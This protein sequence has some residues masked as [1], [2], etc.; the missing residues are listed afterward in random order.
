MNKFCSNCGAEVGVEVKICPKCNTALLPE[1][2]IGVRKEIKYLSAGCGGCLTVILFIIFAFSMYA[3]VPSIFAFIISSIIT[4]FPVILYILAILWLDRHEKEP[5]YLIA[6][7]FLW[8]ALV[9]FLFSIAI[10]SIYGDFA[11]RLISSEYYSSMFQSCIIAPIVEES[12]KGAALLLLFIFMRHEFDNVTDG[13]IY[14][15]LIGLGF[16][17]TEDILYYARHYF[18]S[19][20]LPALGKIFLIRSVFSGLGHSLYTGTTGAGLGF[21]R[22]TNKGLAV[23]IIVP[24]AAFCLAMAEHSLWNL[25][26]FLPLPK[27]SEWVDILVMTP[28]QSAILSL[29]I[30]LTL[31]AVAY[32]A[33]RQEKKVIKEHLVEELKS[34]IVLPSEYEALT[35]GGRFSREWE[36]L[37]EKGIAAWYYLRKLYQL[38][39]N[40]AFRKWHSAR[41]ERLKGIQRRYSEEA[42]RAQIQGVRT[43]II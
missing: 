29:P 24:V 26:S 9:C 10:N 35:R 31:L 33:L 15:S 12:T 5:F 21:A 22:Q 18:Y 40:L 1:W 6:G 23:K 37:W 20:G 25:Y 42:I 19:G 3:M 28:L 16:S 41:G 13:I 14:G 4:V 17:L 7:T 36:I 43:K 2:E 8:G 34:G 32:F 27:V 30:L 38:E 39:V 11:A